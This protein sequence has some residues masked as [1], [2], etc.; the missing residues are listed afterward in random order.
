MRYVALILPTIITLFTFASIFLNVNE[1]GYP[2]H[3]P[4]S[5]SEPFA[6][7][8]LFTS[9]GCSSCPSADELLSKI[10]NE[11]K[12]NQQN[13]YGL[14]FHVNYWDH[15]GWKDKFSDENYTV[16]QKKYTQTLANTQVYTPQMI[17]NGT[18][19]FVGSNQKEAEKAIRNA[20][21]QK[22]EASIRLYGDLET[23]S[24]I[25]QLKYDIQGAT[26]GQVLHVALI[27]Q[28]LENY[29]TKGENKGH[30]LHHEN[31][32]R[33]FKTV[34]LN[35]SGFGEVDLQLPAGINLKNASV[36]AYVQAPETLKIMAATSLK[37]KV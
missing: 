29:V 27:E 25:I 1:I 7:V 3:S 4:S 9:E 19:V 11:A 21:S 24:D 23:V 18:S 26:A 34:T 12:E 17:V 5:Q 13:I 32:V 2:L 33:S 15:L 31:V 6:V 14:G 10:I 30:L 35:G 20:L 37:M 16:R 36:I 28:S 8:E 22:A